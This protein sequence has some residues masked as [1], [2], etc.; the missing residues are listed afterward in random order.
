MTTTYYCPFISITGYDPYGIKYFET[1]N[2][3]HRKLT[4]R[5]ARPICP[6]EGNNM[7]FRIQMPIPTDYTKF[8]MYVPT[9]T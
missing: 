4:I 5:L 7:S 2:S 1:V 9:I 3:T 6:A 8:Y